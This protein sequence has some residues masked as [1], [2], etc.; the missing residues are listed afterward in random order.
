MSGLDLVL[1]KGEE[2]PKCFNFMPHMY[3]E[4]LL[5]SISSF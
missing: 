5:K 1:P 4:D 2:K 3:F